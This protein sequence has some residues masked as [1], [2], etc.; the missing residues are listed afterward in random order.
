MHLPTTGWQGNLPLLTIDLKA[1]RLKL[2][3]L[4]AGRDNNF[5]LIRV[6]AAYAV[7]ISHSYALT[8]GTGDAEPRLARSGRASVRLRCTSFF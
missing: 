4:S 6:L 7:L 3:D 2:G 5:N 8:A 1:I